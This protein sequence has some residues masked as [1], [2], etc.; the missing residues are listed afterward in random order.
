MLAIFST[1]KFIESTIDIFFIERRC[2]SKDENLE[3]LW[4]LGNSRILF[5]QD[6]RMLVEFMFAF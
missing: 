2:H 1:R 6:F 5:L 3:M 4:I